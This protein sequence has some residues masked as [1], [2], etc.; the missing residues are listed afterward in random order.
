M[1]TKE[2]IRKYKEDTALN[3]NL[4]FLINSRDKEELDLIAKDCETNTSELLRM[5]IKEFIKEQKK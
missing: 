3:F 5:L 1:L 2:K 4:N